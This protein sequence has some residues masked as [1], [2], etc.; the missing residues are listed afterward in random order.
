MAH[1]C[2][3]E[4]PS[5]VIEKTRVRCASVCAFRLMPDTCPDALD[6]MEIDP[7]CGS[8]CTALGLPC[9][10]GD[11]SSTMHITVRSTHALYI[12]TVHYILQECPCICNRLHTSYIA[13]L[14]AT[15]FDFRFFLGS[16]LLGENWSSFIFTG[17]HWPTFIIFLLGVNEQLSSISST[18]IACYI[19]ISCPQF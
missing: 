3:V 10:N 2:S 19:H 1:L 6:V 4:V 14:G 12:A 17:Q 11:L 5:P 13:P 15:I 16:D 8:I 7:C 9:S 18:Y